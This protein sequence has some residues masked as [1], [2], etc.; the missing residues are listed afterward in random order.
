MIAM[1]R[2][3]SCTLAS[4]KDEVR[5][6]LRDLARGGLA[7][8]ALAERVGPL[9]EKHAPRSEEDLVSVARHTP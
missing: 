3:R 6:A 2:R 8:E 7:G 9:A 5:I 1:R 4:L